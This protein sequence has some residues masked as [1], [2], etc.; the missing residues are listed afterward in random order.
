MYRRLDVSPQASA[1]QIRH[2]YRRLAQDVHPDTHPDD[3]DA[4]RR[5]QEI[6][7]AYEVLIDPTR[8]ARYDRQRRSTGAPLAEDG[9]AIRRRAPQ[10]GSPP[11]IAGPVHVEPPATGLGPS[12]ASP[13]RGVDLLDL[14][15]ALMGRRWR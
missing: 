2:A 13:G 6:T 8:R 4:P 15:D 3:P 14:L 11:L 9:E 12:P 1:Q 7:E 10:P 5:F